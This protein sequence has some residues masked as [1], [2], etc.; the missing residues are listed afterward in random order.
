[1]ITGDIILIEFPFTDLSDSK[2]R[3]A[4]VV[5]ITPDAYEDI[6]VC[7]ISSVI[8]TRLNNFQLLIPPTQV[9]GLRS[10]SVI[11]V[12][13]IATVANTKMITSIGKLS[14]QELQLFVAAFQSLVLS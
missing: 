12:Y 1:M 6:I 13:K 8:P 10:V 2:V 4:V 11:H 14:E 9:N 3:P 5:S 7:M